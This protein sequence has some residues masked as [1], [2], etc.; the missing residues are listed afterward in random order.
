MR[1]TLVILARK[2]KKGMV[3]MMDVYAKGIEIRW[4][5]GESCGSDG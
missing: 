3:K 1:Y 2:D 5:D 4:R